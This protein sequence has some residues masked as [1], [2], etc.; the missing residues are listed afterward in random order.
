MNR[1]HISVWKRRLALGLAVALSAGNLVFHLSIS[2]LCDSLYRT[3][4]RTVYERL[5]LF[6]IVGLSVLAAAPWLKRRIR[7]LSEPRTAAASLALVVLACVAQT[8]LLVSNVELIHF[9]QYALLA[10]LLLAAGMTAE[11]AFAAASAA[12]IL[13]EAYQYYVLYAGIPKVYLDFNDMYLNALGAALA[14]ALMA[15]GKG[16]RAEDARRERR[17][18]GK[19]LLLL[20]AALPIVAWA[21]PPRLHPYWVRAATGRSYHVMSASE[22]LALG[23]LVWL[24]VRA[25]CPAAPGDRKTRGQPTA[26]GARSRKPPLGR[27]ASPYAVRLTPHPAGAGG[28]GRGLGLHRVAG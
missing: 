21:D 9:P 17:T 23:L 10:G 24:L 22:T 6:G 13:D 11:P 19:A 15:G 14:V 26:Y 27:K 1:A 5:T 12:G 4:G 25:A 7:A 28:R 20:L 3:L 18:W 8:S 16:P 2:D